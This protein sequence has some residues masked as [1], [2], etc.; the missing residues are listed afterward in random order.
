MKVFRFSIAALLIMCVFIGI[1]SYKI[2]KVQKKI[3]DLGKEILTLAR[4]DKWDEVIPLFSKVEEDWKDFNTWATL[5]MNTKDIGELEIS[6]NQ[7]K[8]LALLREKGD[9][10]SEFTLFL[11]MARHVASQE[12]LHWE[13]IF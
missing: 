4:E 12:G 7:S 11:N 13:E 3:D 5:T 2:T 10:L 9:F 6:L 1:H 8:I